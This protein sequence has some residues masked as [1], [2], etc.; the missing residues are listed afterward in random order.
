MANVNN[1][2]LK[3]RLKS[4][5]FFIYATEIAILAVDVVLTALLMAGGLAFTAGLAVFLITSSIFIGHSFDGFDL[6]L[7]HIINGK[8]CPSFFKK[9]FGK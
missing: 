4:N 2:V 1:S 6:Y 3:E 9:N 8:N 7:Y 5:K